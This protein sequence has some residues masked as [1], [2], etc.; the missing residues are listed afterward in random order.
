MEEV[1]RVNT[2]RLCLK[3]R[4]TPAE[5][6]DIDMQDMADIMVFAEEEAR[7]NPLGSG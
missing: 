4:K 6:D 3:L 1:F 7:R 2:A 5:L